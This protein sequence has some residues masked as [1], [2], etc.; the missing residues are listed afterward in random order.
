[1]DMEGHSN[2]L[3]GVHAAR[4]Q[5]VNVTCPAAGRSEDSEAPS[6][7]SERRVQAP[8]TPE[9]SAIF[10]PA[11]KPERQKFA[12]TASQWLNAW[13][14]NKNKRITTARIETMLARHIHPNYAKLC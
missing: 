1:M 13:P 8:Q 6:S 12:E 4:Q 10:L 9:P 5:Q 14:E 2:T 7:A 3:D 11:N